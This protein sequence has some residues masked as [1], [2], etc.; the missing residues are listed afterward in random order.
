MTLP[1]SLIEGCQLRAV[2]GDEDSEQA[3]RLR[4]ARILADEMLTSGWLEEAFA[5]LVDFD[6]SG[7]GV[8]GSD[9]AGEHVGED[10]S[11]VVMLA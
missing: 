10:A 6:W 11:G 2:I 3:R 4:C 9:R 7:R 5:G 8:L 1:G